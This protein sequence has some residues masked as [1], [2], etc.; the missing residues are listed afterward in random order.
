MPDEYHGDLKEF[1]TITD[2]DITKRAG[3]KIERGKSKR[4]PT[5]G[6]IAGLHEGWPTEAELR[7]ETASAFDTATAA[8]GTRSSPRCRAEDDASES[9]RIRL[10]RLTSGFPRR[11]L[12]VTTPRSPS[13]HSP[14]PRRSS[15]L[16]GERVGPGRGWD[17]DD[18]ARFRRRSAETAEGLTVDKCHRGLGRVLLPR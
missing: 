15:R 1:L 12:L 4:K 7:A 10:S 18:G 14:S 6:S 11:N 17:G 13:S 2:P 3:K 9:S 16:A 8:V 5:I